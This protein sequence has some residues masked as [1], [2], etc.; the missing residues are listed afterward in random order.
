MSYVPI[1]QPADPLEKASLFSAFHLKS[2]QALVEPLSRQLRSLPI[3]SDADKVLYVCL[4]QDASLGEEGYRILTTPDTVHIEGCSERALYYA[5]ASLKLTLFSQRSML[6]CGTQSNAPAFKH[7]GV[8]LDVSRGKM[9]TL[10]YLKNLI[11]YLSDL[12]YNVLQLYCEDKLALSTHPE[13]GLLTGA[14]SERDIRELDDCCRMCHME[15]QP[16]IQTYSHMHGV[17]R[18]PENCSLA[19]NDVLFSFAAGSEGVYAF[20]RE[21]LAE[22]LPWFSSSTLNIC[23]DEAYDI[24]T[25]YSKD[26]VKASGSGRVL[27]DHIKRVID[28]ARDCGAEKIL[29]WGDAAH[30]YPELMHELPEHVALIDW[31]YNALESF[32]ALAE[33]AVTGREFWAAGGV[34]SWNSIFPRMYQAYQNLSNYARDAKACRADGFLVT[35]WGDYGHTQPLGLSLYGYFVGAEHAYSGGISTQGQLQTTAMPL[36]FRDERVYAAFQALMDSNLAENL[37]TDF[38]TMSLY[39]F[40][41]DLLDGMSLRGSERY[42]A[43]T[44][45]TFETLTRCG[46]SARIKLDAYAHEPDKP[47]DWPDEDWASLFDSDFLAE[48]ALSAR[49]THY[50]GR[51]GQLS[52]RIRQ[53]LQSA[54]LTPPALLDLI[55]KIHLLYAEFAA[56]R[57]DFERVWLLRTQRRGIEASLSLFDRAGV[58]LAEAVKWLALQRERLLH[59][60]PIDGLLTTYTA[61]RAYHILWTADFTNMWDRAYPWQ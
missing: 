61:G 43:L 23:M 36:I 47:H 8:M 54:A 44:A 20:L 31:N 11:G 18:L 42:P 10:S 14:Y 25:G 2:D 4:V 55:R 29:L 52:V 24:G 49:M 19:E 39:W 45:S 32:P 59:G 57:S 35:D 1:P 53:E 58:Q 38:K 33:V 48:L 26:A 22:A 37:Q 15:L 46:E 34:S 3:R 50:A 7:R 9:P 40:F 6:A 27:L 56:I 28:I 51:K 12:Q 41:D 5:L 17:L 13:V 21:E 30:K 16:C 60:E